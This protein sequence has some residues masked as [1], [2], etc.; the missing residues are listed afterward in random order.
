MA[1]VYGIIYKATNKINGKIYIGQTVQPLN[2][3]I[4][5]HLC[6]ALLKKDNSYF[7]NAIRKYGKEN[8]IWEIVAECNLLEELN[9]AEVKTIEKYNTFENG[10]NL[11]RG[12]EGSIGFKP[13]NET[14][15]K[16]SGSHMGKT[17]SEEARRKIS[18]SQIGEKNY[19]FGRC[20]TEETKR[21]MSESHIGKI[22]SE[23]TKK[24]IGESQRGEKN[25][26]YGRRGNKSPKARKYIVITPDEKEIF[27]HG[28]RNFCRN[29]KKEKLYHQN[30]V[31]VAQGKQ[32]YYKGYK[33]K[34]LKGETDG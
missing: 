7:H 13:S 28:I 20:P 18:E 1:K 27:I 25:Y 5:E 6:H 16:M 29:Y 8:F 2:K 30:L 15:R 23:E 24:K 10:Y 32:E 19:N 12:G 21:K 14:K 3:R 26:M 34:Y 17:L 4:I 11:T 31:R 33:C 9:R 22:F